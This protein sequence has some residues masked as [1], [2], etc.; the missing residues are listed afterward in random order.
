[1]RSDM[2]K[3]IVERPR[4]RRPLNNG[5]AYP[6]GHLKNRWLPNLEDAPRIESMGGTYAEKWLNENLQPLV[7]FL[8]SSVGRRWDDVHSEIAAQI[9]C[10]SAVQKHVL[11]HLRDYV[12]E[13]VRIVGSTV[14]YIRHHW[15]QPLESVGMRF[16]FYVA[17]GTRELCLA[18]VV[19]RK[20]P[21]KDETDPDRRIL[22]R[23]RELRRI[24][25]V[26][27]EIDVAPIPRD[28][29]ARAACFDVLER[30]TLDGGAYDARTRENVLWQTARYAACKRQLST[31]EIVRRS[32]R[33]SR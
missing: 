3:V 8:R 13:N 10:K 18:P 2:S 1:M 16:R 24:H 4:L 26:W 15:Y 30:T 32:L 17:P 12:V 11:D 31:R 14:Q 29:S 20:R 19:S 27:Y 25:G 5:S 9:S 7:R 6:R 23:D 21:K 22:S 28:P 33:R